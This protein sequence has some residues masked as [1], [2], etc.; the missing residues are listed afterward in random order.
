MGILSSE[1]MDKAYLIANKM[2]Y[3]DLSTNSSFMNNYSASLF[4]P[5]T[6]IEMFPSVKKILS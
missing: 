6:D 1:A 4:I 5:H 3:V 2:T